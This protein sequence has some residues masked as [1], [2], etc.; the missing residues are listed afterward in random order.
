MRICRPYPTSLRGYLYLYL[1]LISCSLPSIAQVNITERGY[2]KN[3]TG[4]NPVETT[5]TP[6]NVSSTANR[7]H[8]QFVMKVDGKIESFPLYVSGVHISG[9][10]HNVLYV[11]TMHNTVFAFDADDGTMLSTRWLGNP[12]NDGDLDKLGKTTIHKEWGILSTPVIDLKTGTLYVVRWGY[13]NGVDGPRFRLYG[14]D[15]TNLSQDKIQSVRIDG[16]NVNGM[17][18]DHTVQLQRAGLAL[19]QKPDGH[20]AVV[21]GFGGGEG[22]GGKSGWV[23]AYDTAKLALGTATANFWCTTPGNGGGGGGVWMANAAPAIDDKGDIYVV[24]GNGPYHPQF[25]AD[26][27]GESVVHLIWNPGNPGSLTV[28]DWFTPFVDNDRDDPHR[29]QDFASGG[30]IALP[31]EAALIAGGKDGVYYHVSRADMGK[32]TFSTLLDPP[33]VAS[34]DYKPTNGHTS[35]FDNLNQ[36]SSTDPFTVGPATSGRTPHIHGTGVYFDNLLFVQGENNK[37]HVFSKTGGHFSAEPVARGTST[38]SWGTSSPGGMP[39]GILA[40]SANGTSGG[41]LWANEAF[42][43]LYYDPGANLHPTPNVLRAYDVSTVASGTLQ[44]IW[45][46]EAAPGD[47]LGSATKFTPP[48]VANGRVYQVT[49]DNQVVVYGLGAPSPTPKRDVHRTVVFIFGKTLTGQFLFVR[50]GARGGKPIRILH[51]N[52][53]NDETSEYRFGDANLDFDG[54]ELGQASPSG[55]FGG[56]SPLDWTTSLAD[57]QGQQPFVST[58]GYGIA[59]E[60]TF[61]PNYWM[62][63]VDMDCEQAFDD[64]HGN[65]WFELQAR[66]TPRPGPEGSITQVSTPAPPYVSKNHMGICGMVNVFVANYDDRPA[67]LD[68][69]SAQFLKP[70]YTYPWPVDDRDAPIEALQNTPCV[71]PTAENRCVANISQTCTH[72][73]TG[74]FFRTVENCNLKPADGDTTGNYGQMCNRA[75]GK[76]CTPHGKDICKSVEP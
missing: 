71:S 26:Q 8:K 70:G 2:N 68:P 5:L 43:N 39:G 42:G 38:A 65:R 41:I 1:L 49:Y 35:L 10:T 36:V 22:P 17:E 13:D 52:W 4:V 72:T 23:V 12:V 55:N 30:V 45:D 58:R 61:G 33:F 69:N 64:G 75:S 9:G 7:F 21:I 56:G 53:L 25:A 62:L 37:V 60:N 29:D 54:A 47:H 51:R 14:L 50:G 3:R 73:N 32:R 11:T 76:C 59:D 15:I 46:S 63:D 19:A 31:D 16:F 20:Q 6:A 57:G 28:S 34:F 74:N 24:T 40:L 27:L 48:L 18:F 66:I 44:S 67:G